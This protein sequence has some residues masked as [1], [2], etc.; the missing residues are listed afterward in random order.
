MQ[1]YN[2]LIFII[3]VSILLLGLPICRVVVI[4]IVEFH[5]NGS[6]VRANGTLKSNKVLAGLVCFVKTVRSPC[7]IFW[8]KQTSRT[9]LLRMA[10][11]QP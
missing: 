6:T 7:F 3:I 8:L 4:V 5:A 9:G 11:V 2:S 1:G 10:F